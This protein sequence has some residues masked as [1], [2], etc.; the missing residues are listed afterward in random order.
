MTNIKNLL[1]H[2][3]HVLKDNGDAPN[4]VQCTYGRFLPHIGAVDPEVQKCL[5]SDLP[6]GDL[7][8]LICHSEKHRY[9]LVRKGK[10]PRI[11]A[12]RKAWQDVRD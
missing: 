11:T 4:D 7:S 10:G 8:V 9:E 1:L 6:D 3:L 2:V 5:A 12:V